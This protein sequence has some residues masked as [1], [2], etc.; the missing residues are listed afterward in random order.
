MNKRILFGVILVAALAVGALM[1]LVIAEGVELVAAGVLFLS[2]TVGGVALRGFLRNVPKPADIGLERRPPE[3][4]PGRRRQQS[5]GGRSRS[6][7][8]EGSGGPGGRQSR[9]NTGTKKGERLEGKVKWFDETKGFGFITPDDGQDDCFVHR[10]AVPGG[11]PLAE[12]GR[13]A[14]HIITDEK[15]R[16]AAAEVSLL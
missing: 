13:V 14:F 3:P 6:K 10:S 16:K 2:G 5:G 11:K 12:G 15:G 7:G 1:A 4:R 8:R 9:G